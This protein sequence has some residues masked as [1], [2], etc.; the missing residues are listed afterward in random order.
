MLEPEQCALWL[1]MPER[2]LGEKFRKGQVPGAK[3]GH[4]TIRYHPR[5][6]IAAKVKI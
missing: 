6:I 1:Q 5:T 2:E 4:K 3:M